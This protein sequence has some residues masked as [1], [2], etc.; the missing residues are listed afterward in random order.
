MSLFRYIGGVNHS[1]K[2][3]QTK[4]FLLSA[5]DCYIEHVRWVRPST[6]F[7]P[8][9]LLFMCGVGCCNMQNQVISKKQVILR[10][11]L[12]VI[13]SFCPFILIG[14]ISFN[15][16]L[17]LYYFKHTRIQFHSLPV[18]KPFEALSTQEQ[19]FMLPMS[20]PI[21]ALSFVI[22]YDQV[23]Q[24]SVDVYEFHKGLFI[25]CILFL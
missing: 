17:Q 8:Q 15:L 10:S 13:G 22:N 21:E 19:S 16:I 7:G 11:H 2:R 1:E 5:Y 24:N 12:H 23:V 9:I 18:S 25:T 14:P 20:K 6:C 3:N 4:S